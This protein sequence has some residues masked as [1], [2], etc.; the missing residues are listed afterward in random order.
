MLVNA[1]GFLGNALSVL[2]FLPNALTVWR[3]R[4][5]SHALKGVSRYMQY[6]ILANASTWAVYAWLT[7]AYWAAAPGLF[8]APLAI[9]VLT[10]LHRSKT[11][12]GN[13]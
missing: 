11:Q 6:G 10:L 13:K 5:D 9:F 3:N 12:L 2:L 7:G 4:H 1:V 8:N